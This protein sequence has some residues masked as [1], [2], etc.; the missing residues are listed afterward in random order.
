MHHLAPVIHL[1]FFF[2]ACL[3]FVLESMQMDVICFQ[4]V[5]EALHEVLMFGTLCPMRIL[6]HI[7]SHNQKKTCEERSVLGSVTIGRVLA[8]KTPLSSSFNDGA[9][10]CAICFSLS[11]QLSYSREQ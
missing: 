9:H 2:C 6:S 3:D 10:T 4:N 7:H 11:T 5:L 1:L 8:L